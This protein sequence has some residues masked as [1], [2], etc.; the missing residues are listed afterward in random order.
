MI[1][2]LETLIQYVIVIILTDLVRT[3]TNQLTLVMLKTIRVSKCLNH[4]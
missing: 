2:T 3:F 1:F 4:N